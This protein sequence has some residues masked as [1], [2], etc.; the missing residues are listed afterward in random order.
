MVQTYTYQKDYLD[1]RANARQQ[2]SVTYLVRKESLYNAVVVAV[3][4]AT[5]G[6]WFKSSH[7]QKFIFY[8]CF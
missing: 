6:P 2:H 8:I 1:K 7:R 5:M 3:A 4:S